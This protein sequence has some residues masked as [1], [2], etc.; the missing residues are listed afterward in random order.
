M[1]TE[2]VL[3]FVLFAIVAAITPGPSNV[4]LASTGANAGV[5]RGLPTLFG[6]TLGMG[7]MMF[8]VAF[9]LGSLV[10]AN[11]VILRGL[12]WGGVAVLLWLAWKIATA[13]RGG[14]PATTGV[15]GFWQAAALQ[16]VNPKAWIVCASAAGAYLHAGT[17]SPIVQAAAL[18][19]LF[20]LAA[21]PSCL[22]WLV[23][24]ASLQ[25]WLHSERARRRFNLAMGVLLAASVVLFV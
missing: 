19:L 16:G 10:L 25:R 9:G 14:A 23:L 6:L 1:T 8:L 11:P 21:V 12:K 18:G 24:G 13:S 20:V 7:S 22:V 17:A 4:I 5:R 3:A 15:L 2:Q